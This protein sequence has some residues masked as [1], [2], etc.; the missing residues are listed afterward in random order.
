MPFFAVLLPCILGLIITLKF[1]KVRILGITGGI[2]TGKST[3]TRLI[4]DNFKNIDIIDC[5]DISR[6]LR[7]KG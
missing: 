5:D 7:R 3:L 6:K 1:E 2:A 4:K